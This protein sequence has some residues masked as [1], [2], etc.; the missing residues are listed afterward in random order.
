MS[1]VPLNNTYE[2][3]MDFGSSSEQS[4]YF[5]GKTAFTHSDFTYVKE[6]GSIK[7]PR[8]RD[9]LYAVNYIMFRNSDF[10]SKWFYAFVK[11]LEYVNPSTTKVHFELDVFQTWQFDFSLKPSFVERE[12]QNRWN[13]DG[14][15]VVNTLDEGLDYGSEYQTV[16]VQQFTPMSDTFF[17]V[18][19]CKQR[20]DVNS[21]KIEPNVNGGI[22]PLTYY[23][24]PF[25]MDGSVPGITVDGMSQTLSPVA[26]VLKALYTSTVAVN[27]IANLYITEY[28]GHDSLSFNMQEFEPVNVQDKD[29]STNITTLRVKKMS[30]YRLLT[31]DMGEKYDGFSSVTESKLLM[32][33]YTVTVLTDMKGNFQEIKNE[34]VQ[35][36]HLFVTVKGSIGTSNKVSYN[37]Y[38]Y[39][40]NEDVVTN[41]GE[42]ALERA[43]INNSP[44]DVPIIT[45][46][47]SAYLQGNRN[48]LANQTNQIAFSSIAGSI[49]SAMGSIGS[50]LGRNPVGAVSGI[51][52]IGMN[53]ANSYFQLQGLMAKQKDLNATPP[54]LSNMGGNTAFDYG[55]DLKGLYIIKKEI[56]PE[57]RKK[58]T[59]F[60][61]MF[62]YKCNEVKTPNLK[63][64]AHFNFIK[65]TGAN[66]TGNV[67]Q[68]DLVVIKKMFDNGVTL[69]HTPDVG[70]YALT[71]GEV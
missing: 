7:V 18:V 17:L 3:Q 5:I 29:T 51:A 52:D 42:V 9:S 41:G 66:V 49:G 33:P 19:V 1:G 64:R 65:T 13:A 38:N 70:N 45:D 59:D 39:L 15:P 50:A 25:K 62:G 24:H 4:T 60:F 35:D 10:S 54:Q 11:K 2:H 61:K 63:S 40:M 27:N 56:T 8:S 16:K 68:E 58:L 44:N 14:T 21:D 12:H 69:W 37:I 6:D 23:V 31:W 48:S 53:M 26:D 46:L 43:I 28:I 57:Y 71:N 34:Y 30:A 20:M 55:N 36:S 32:Y 67:P 47:L 22:Q